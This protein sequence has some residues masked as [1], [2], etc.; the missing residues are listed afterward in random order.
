M[1]DNFL[2]F[3]KRSLFFTTI[4]LTFLLFTQDKKV[5]DFTYIFLG[6][7][8]ILINCFLIINFIK[9]EKYKNTFAKYK[10]NNY[11]S[12]FIMVIILIAFLYL[13]FRV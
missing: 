7:I 8:I 9:S 5:N 6:I 10:L 12:L 4:V 11:S 13:H 1:R 2:N 3:S